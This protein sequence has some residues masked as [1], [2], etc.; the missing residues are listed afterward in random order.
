MSE[1]HFDPTEWITTTEAAESTGYCGD[2][3]VKAYHKGVLHSIKRGHTRFYRKS[4]I[5]A[6]VERMKELGPQKHTPKKYLEI[7]KPAD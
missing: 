5:L 1:Q 4:D 2:T 7:E 6:Y 3:F